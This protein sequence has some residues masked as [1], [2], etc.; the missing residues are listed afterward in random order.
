MGMF[1]SFLNPHIEDNEVQ[2]LT[3]T[4]CFIL[5][6]PGTMPPPPGSLPCLPRHN[7]SSLIWAPQPRMPRSQGP[8]SLL[9]ALTTER[10]V[11]GG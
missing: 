11:P 3:E 9:L 2:R 8:L 6:G 7:S 5:Q 10:S 4:T 1:G